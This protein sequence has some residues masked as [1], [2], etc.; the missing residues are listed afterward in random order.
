[1]FGTLPQQYIINLHI[2]MLQHVETHLI[3]LNLALY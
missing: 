3:K 1:M 2:P